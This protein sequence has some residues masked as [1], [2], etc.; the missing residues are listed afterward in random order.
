M[1]KIMIILIFLILISTVF[2]TTGSAKQI[3]DIN[4]KNLTIYSLLSYDNNP[5]NPPIINGPTSG[6]IKET[7]EYVFTL[8]DQDDDYLTKL[9]ID[10]GDG[11]TTE[12]CWTCGGQLQ[13][14]GTEYVVEHTWRKTGSYS[15]KA[16]VWDTQ[17][18]ESDWSEPFSVSMP[19]NKPIKIMMLIEELEPFQKI[20]ILLKNL[21]KY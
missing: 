4:T 19:K 6:K 5:P 10:W 21:L 17:N 9:L 16:K 20:F 8:I 7:Y 15:I 12:E 18:A 3:S 14:N 11:T 2:L 1:K 13:K